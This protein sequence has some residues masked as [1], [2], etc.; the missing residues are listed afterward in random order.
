MKRQY[1]TKPSGR[2][3]DCGEHFFSRTS[4]WGTVLVSPEDGNFL[5]DFVWTLL[6]AGN[7]HF[8]ARSTRLV[9]STNKSGS[10]HRCILP[11]APMVDH[12]DGNGLD[13]RRHNIRIASRGQNKV[14]T[15]KTNTRSGFRGV[16]VNSSGMG[17]GW[18]AAVKHDGKYHHL[19]YFDDPRIAADAVNVK[20]KEIFGEFAPSVRSPDNH[21]PTARASDGDISIP[22]DR[23]GS[24]PA[25]R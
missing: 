21:R 15:R 12:V 10:I 20:L 1:Q 17:V 22:P 16:F 24:T 23:R 9:A 6:K 19:G 14:N 11:T 18:R 2:R 7:G 8:Y 5:I 25:S 3:C 13:N 4:R